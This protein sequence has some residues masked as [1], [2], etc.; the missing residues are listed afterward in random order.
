MSTEPLNV[1]LPVVSVLIGALIPEIRPLLME[2]RKYY[3]EKKDQSLKTLNS[4]Y[5]SL[6]G[7]LIELPEKLPIE[8]LK[9]AGVNIHN[10]ISWYDC[11]K[12]LTEEHKEL[13]FSSPEDDDTN[14]ED[15]IN[16]CEAT[17]FDMKNKYNNFRKVYNDFKRSYGKNYELK[18]SDKVRS[19]F[20]NL[21]KTVFEAYDESIYRVAKTEDKTKGALLTNFS[22]E[23]SKND[24]INLIRSELKE[25]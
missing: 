24:L 14:G 18:A 10:N 16:Y 23:D 12:I 13:Y 7:V 2:D 4:I 6:V 8:I 15:L 3:R 1:I 22:L 9:E 5:A 19:E 11:R 25:K 17:L 20:N 21:Y